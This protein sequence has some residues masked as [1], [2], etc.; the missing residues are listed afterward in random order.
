MPGAAVGVDHLE[1]GF[2]SRYASSMK[3][4]KISL[5]T[6][7]VHVRSCDRIL[8][9][10]MTTQRRSSSS[11][12]VQHE[13]VLCRQSRLRRHRPAAAHGSCT[14]GSTC[15]TSPP[16]F[17]MARRIRRPS[18]LNGCHCARSRYLWPDR[19][20]A[21]PLR[22]DL[23]VRWRAFRRADLRDSARLDGNTHASTSSALAV[24]DTGDEIA[25]LRIPV[26][27]LHTDPIVP[28]SG[29]A[30]SDAIH[31]PNRRRRCAY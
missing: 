2:T 8:L 25:R 21:V 29:P 31:L 15:S 3:R 7:V 18:R 19:I 30:G 11:A 20:L 27:V 24:V 1:V 6:F 13:P 28:F 17:G 23:R 26:A 14:T 22:A 9:M 16:K 4:S 10:T 12:S 5:I